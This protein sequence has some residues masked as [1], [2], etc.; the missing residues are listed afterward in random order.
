MDWHYYMNESLHKDIF[1]PIG[2]SYIIGRQQQNRL[3]AI[4]LLIAY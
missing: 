1:E 4:I 3:V 2:S